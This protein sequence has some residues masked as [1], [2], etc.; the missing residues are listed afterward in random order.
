MRFSSAD[1]APRLTDRAGWTRLG[2]A[3]LLGLVAAVGPVVG[4][5]SAQFTDTS[6]VG[7]GTVGTPDD[8]ASPTPGATPGTGQPTAGPGSGSDDPTAGGTDDPSTTP[9][10]PSAG[11]DRTGPDRTG[12]TPNHQRPRTAPCAR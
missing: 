8:F 12:P 4:H 6:E 10:R 1:G 2:A 9:A 5:T 11:P 7:L 3:V